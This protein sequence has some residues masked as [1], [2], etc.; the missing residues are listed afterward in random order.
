[1]LTNARK[2]DTPDAIIE[3][4]ERTARRSES[5][6]YRGEVIL[7][8]SS[9][10]ELLEDIAAVGEFLDSRRQAQKQQTASNAIRRAEEILRRAA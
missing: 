2:C 6:E 9:R 5:M 4:G 1:M 7:I 10:R 3:L 8:R